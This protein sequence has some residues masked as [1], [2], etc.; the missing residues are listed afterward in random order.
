MGMDASKKILVL[1]RRLSW[2]KSKLERR[3]EASKGDG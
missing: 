1:A 3:K 2:L